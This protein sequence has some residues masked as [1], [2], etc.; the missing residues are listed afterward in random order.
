LN[1]PEKGEQAK[2]VS[3]NIERGGDEYHLLDLYGMKKEK[4]GPKKRGEESPPPIKRVRIWNTT[5]PVPRWSRIPK[6]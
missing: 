6:A 2:Q 1:V 3:K 5:H 4:Q